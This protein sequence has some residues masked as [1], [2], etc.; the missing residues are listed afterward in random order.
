L[1]RERWQPSANDMASGLR[2]VA[3]T[4]GVALVA[5]G[6]G[7]SSP[8]SLDY[9]AT[10]NGVLITLSVPG[11]K[12][13]RFGAQPKLAVRFTA[14]AG[15]AWRHVLH[16]R[17][18]EAF[19]IWPEKNGS[20]MSTINVQVRSKHLALPFPSQVSASTGTYTCGLHARTGGAPESWPAYVRAAL[21]AA[22]LRQT[23][24]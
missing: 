6:C 18:Q 8:S 10:S 4:C 11:K 13:A 20:G 7:G 24:N 17:K 15:T 2:I 21:V 1:P 19:C 9:R 22:R 3:V 12:A 23:H 14:A 5:G 16:L